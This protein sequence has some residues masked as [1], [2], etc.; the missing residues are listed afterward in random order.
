MQKSDWIWGGE[1]FCARFFKKVSFL[2][3]IKCCPNFLDSALNKYVKFYN[4]DKSSKYIVYFDVN[5][6]CEGAMT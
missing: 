6:L 5:N 3:D 2:A 4:E 1:S